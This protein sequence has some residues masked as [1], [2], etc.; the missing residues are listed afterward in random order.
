MSSQTHSGRQMKTT[1]LNRRR[2]TTGAIMAAATVF[3]ACKSD[4][5]LNVSTPDFLGVD[6]YS[7]PA[8]VDPLRFGVLSDFAYAYDGNNDA[9]TVISGDLADE[10][11]TT[12]TF[13]GRLTVNARR[14]AEINS[15]MESEY[16]KMQQAHLGAVTATQTLATAA[17]TLK[18]QRGEMFLI[19]GFT[20]VFFAEGWCSGTAF[21]SQSGGTTVYGNP[22]STQDLFQLAVASF[23]SAIALADTSKRV[24][25]GAELGRARALLALAKY[26]D[27]A[28][29]VAN[30]PRTFQFLIT[31]STAS[32]RENNGMWTGAAN[33][34][35]RYSVITSEGGNGLPYL[36]TPAD[37]RMPWTPSARTGFDGRSTNLPV[38]TKFGQTTAGILADGTEAQL[39]ILEARLQGGAQSDRDAVFAGLNQLRATNTPAIAPMPGSAPTTQADAVT[40]LFTERAYWGWLTGKRLGD[41]RRLVRNYGRDAEKVFPTGNLPAPQVGTYGTST[42]IVIPFNER[43][44]PNFQGCLDNKP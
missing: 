14:T 28:A 10:I 11:N 13:D 16:R 34:A 26:A 12:D 35:S 19:K 20:E 44:N 23:D 39:D 8:G 42:S 2:L 9:F 15:E 30:V 31:H 29:S 25:Y 7:T 4:E 38:E 36:Q 40:Q 37:P 24:L 22:N 6:A 41:M 32:S 1:G 33:G 17:P 43:N 27:A 3:A 18:W 21:S 5:V